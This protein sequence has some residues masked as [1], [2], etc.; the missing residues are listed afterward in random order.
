MTF[1]A[2]QTSVQV[3][4]AVTD[5]NIDEANETFN[6]TATVTSGTTANTSAVGVGTI[7]DNDPAPTIS[8]NNVT[9]TEGTD[10]Y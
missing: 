6:L 4:V 1:A 10:Q 7:V 8:V 3:R 2:G 9:A 5:D